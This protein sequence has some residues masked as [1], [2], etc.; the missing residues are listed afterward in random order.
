M[1]EKILEIIFIVLAIAFAAGGFG[2]HKLGA[3]S[4]QPAARHP[5][6]LRIVSWNVGG[7]GGYGGRSMNNE[8]LPHVA[9]VL[10][11]LDADLILLQEVAS[12]RQ[13]RRLSRVLEGQWE[14]IVSTGG[15]SLLAILGQ[16]GKLQIQPRL[17][18]SFR[19]LAASYQSTGGPPVLVINIHADPYS[20]KERNTLIGQAADV[21]MKQDSGHLKILAGDLNLDVD[22]E[23]RRD[24]FSD[25]EHLDVETYNYLVQHLSDVTRDTGATAEPDRRL[26][27]IFADAA[28]VRV[29]RAG[30]WKGRRVADMDHDPVVA[31]LQIKE[32]EP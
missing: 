2:I 30:P 10:K 18:R 31:D 15:G 28:R 21:L 17:A 20:A 1:R 27:Y 25:N 5:D 22:I 29:N 12:A 7:A 14:V 4:Y 11:K 16:R 32:S 8:Y 3:G 19:T 9:A 6:D 13:A 23:K 24:L 26:D